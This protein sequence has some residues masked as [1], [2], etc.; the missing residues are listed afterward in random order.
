MSDGSGWSAVAGVRFV[1]SAG[2]RPAVDAVTEILINIDVSDLEQAIEFYQ[3][4]AG[5][6]LG[7]RLFDGTVA[8]MLGASSSIYLLARQPGSSAGS[9]VSQTR[10][11]RRHWTPVHLDFVVEDIEAAIDKALLAGAKLECEA[12]SFVWGCLATLS[13]PFGNGICFVQWQGRGYGEVA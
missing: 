12:R 5:L 7:R 8:E 9:H 11:Y 1:A 10:D 4:A 6:R 3:N 2:R 13:D